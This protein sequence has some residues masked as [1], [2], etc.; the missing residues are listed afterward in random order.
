MYYRHFGLSDEP[1]EASAVPRLLFLSEGHRQCLAALEWGVAQ[2]PSG[3]TLLVGKTGTGKTTL[4]A[5]ILAREYEHIRVVFIGNPQPGFDGILHGLTVELGIDAPPDKTAMLE[6][7]RAFLN[8]LG[9]GERVVVVVDEAQSLDDDAL[10]E[11]RLLANRGPASG[12]RMGLILIGQPQLQRRLMRPELRQLSDRIGARAVLN[13]LSRDEAL[14]Y[15][16]YRMNMCGGST[17]RVFGRGA[18]AHCL[19]H[20]GGIPRRINT[21]CHNAMLIA[22]AAGQAQVDLRSARA[23]VAEYNNPLGEARWFQLAIPWARFWRVGGLLAGTMA[24]G[25]FSMNTKLYFWPS[26]NAHD[27]ALAAQ[28]SPAAPA[29]RPPVLV[30][31]PSEAPLLV[32][33]V[34]TESLDNGDAIASTNRVAA[35]HRPRHHL[36]RRH[37]HSQ[38]PRMSVRRE[39]FSIW[40][41]FAVDR[42][43]R[44]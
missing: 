8:G 33:T 22:S 3:F 11:L 35:K 32:S 25:F 17:A 6:A 18:L 4:V 26:R 19:N 43:S 42:A 16:E 36:R 24:L 29:M 39:R 1:F 30:A 13:P 28:V 2:E 34:P 14:D 41:L 12:K 20:S 37:R 21:I 7:F 10:E 23:A 27:E 44:S 15:V 40:H 5:S 9:P 38:H 31:A